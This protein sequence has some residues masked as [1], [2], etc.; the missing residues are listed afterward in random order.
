MKK[1]NLRKSI[2]YI[3]PLA[4][5]LI[6]LSGCSDKSICLKDRPSSHSLLAKITYNNENKTV[7]VTIY[8]GP[9]EDNNIRYKKVLSKQSNKLWLETDTY[10][11]IVANYKLNGKT[12]QVVNGITLSVSKSCKTCTKPCYYV[13]NTE[14]DLRFKP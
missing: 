3:V 5:L 7:P 14:I 11:T 4:L 6:L 2:I 8:I 12:Y 9:M 1:N 13:E 10:F